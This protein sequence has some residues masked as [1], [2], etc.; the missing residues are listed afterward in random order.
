MAKVT[1]SKI[2][3]DGLSA[4]VTLSNGDELH[5]LVHVDC[6]AAMDSVSRFT[7]EGYVMPVCMPDE[8][9]YN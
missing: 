6:C 2:E 8:K 9:G 1:V 7:I 3:T 4:T 5:G